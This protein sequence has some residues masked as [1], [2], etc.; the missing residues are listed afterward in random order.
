MAGVVIEKDTKSEAGDRALPLPEIV[1][2]A[3]RS[4]R[5]RQAAEQLAAGEGYEVS[6]RVVVDELGA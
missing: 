1:R 6:G 2:T 5:R 4:F 3:L